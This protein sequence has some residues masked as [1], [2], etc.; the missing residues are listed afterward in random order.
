[1]VDQREGSLKR[2]LQLYSNIS[3]KISYEYVVSQE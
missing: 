1:L 2:K 3:W